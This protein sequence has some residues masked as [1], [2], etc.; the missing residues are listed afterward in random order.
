M[1]VENAQQRFQ[2]VAHNDWSVLAVLLNVP[3]FLATFG[4]VPTEISRVCRVA[5]Y[6]DAS[7]DGFAFG[8][9]LYAALR[10]DCSRS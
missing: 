2:N 7:F 10:R 6:P 9:G 4:A 8:L 3:R 1:L 5:R